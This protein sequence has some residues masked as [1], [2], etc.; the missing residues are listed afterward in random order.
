MMTKS[1]FKSGDS[2]DNDFVLKRT[3]ESRPFNN[4]L[5]FFAHKKQ[6]K[7]LYFSS[8]NAIPASYL[9]TLRISYI[10]SIDIIS[11]YSTSKE[12]KTSQIIK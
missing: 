10:V 6:N 5:E 8:I 12:K 2:K 1:K 9:Q 7:E 3:R 4:F 11:P